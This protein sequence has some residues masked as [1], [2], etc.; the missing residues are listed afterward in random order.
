MRSTEWQAGRPVTSAVLY[1]S[2]VDQRDG[3]H[4]PFDWRMASVSGYLS[5][6]AVV[7]AAEIWNIP[8]NSSTQTGR[9]VCFIC[10]AH[11]Q[12]ELSGCVFPLLNLAFELTLPLCVRYLCSSA[13]HFCGVMCWYTLRATLYLLISF[14]VHPIR[15]HSVAYFGF[16]LH[17][18]HTARSTWEQM[19]VVVLFLLLPLSKKRLW[20]KEMSYVLRSVRSWSFDWRSVAFPVWHLVASGS[21]AHL[22]V[23]LWFAQCSLF[24]FALLCFY[25]KC[26]SKCRCYQYF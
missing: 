14:V 20:F 13:L 22:V 6:V 4:S 10:S 21:F 26:M 8:R 3:M 2:P 5:L 1:T 19:F 15:R 9:V 7:V 25:K 17:T 18:V 11:K 16:Y 12:Q 23:L 24:L